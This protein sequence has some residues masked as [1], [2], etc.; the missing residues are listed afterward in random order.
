MTIKWFSG[1]SERADAAISVIDDVL[2]DI[3]NY[4]EDATLQKV[5][6]DYKDELEKQES[7]VPYILSRMN[8]SLSNVVTKNHIV[9]TKSQSSKLTE[10]AKLTYI[11]CGY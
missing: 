7:S 3:Y 10:L 5:L 9:L 2:T 8:I 4:P 1:G 11:P 6:L